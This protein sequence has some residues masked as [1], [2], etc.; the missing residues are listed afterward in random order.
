MHCAKVANNQ[1]KL[2]SCTLLIVQPLFYLC[3]KVEKLS[4]INKSFVRSVLHISTG[5]SREEI[6]NLVK[7]LFIEK[8]EKLMQ[9][10]SCATVGA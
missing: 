8:L 3:F 1:I 7:H 4:E 6:E 5:A 2:Q 10:P 9:T